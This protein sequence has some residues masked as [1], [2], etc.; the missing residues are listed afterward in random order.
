MDRLFGS[1][2]DDYTL[3]KI[4]E[5]LIAILSLVTIYLGIQ[6]ALTWKFLKKKAADSKELISQRNSFNRSTVFIFITGFFMIV[7]EFFQGLEKDAPDFVT[8]ELFELVAVSGLVL[9]FYE[10]HK[11]L[12]RLKKDNK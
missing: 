12:N 1:I 3:Y 5:G 9:F 8:Y 4:I 6:M 10:W 2:V 11:I 7:H